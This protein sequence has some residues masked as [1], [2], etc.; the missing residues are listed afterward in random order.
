[1]QIEITDQVKSEAGKYANKYVNAEKSLK[2]FGNSSA[3]RSKQRQYN[4]AYAG[5]I[6]ELM[7]SKMLE[8]YDYRLSFDEEIR[9]G[10]NVGDGG[11][12]ITGFET[13]GLKFILDKK[14]DIKST[15]GNWLLVERHR[16]TADVYVLLR[17]TVKG[18]HYRGYA[19]R[20]DF[21]DQSL[22]A[23]YTYK[24]GDKLR[25]P[26]DTSKFLDVRLDAPLQFGLP[27]SELRIGGFVDYLKNN[28]TRLKNGRLQ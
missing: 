4:D 26:F 14:I 11:K 9:V 20:E 28:S 2:N 25:N 22:M 21:F 19:L 10:N 5:R 15:N 27:S 12:D 6:G 18:V 24:S 8:K 7:F 16:F 3:I 17:V 1:M 13:D 23:K